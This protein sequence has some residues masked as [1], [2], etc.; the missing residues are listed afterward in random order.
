[1]PCPPRGTVPVN[2]GRAWEIFSL[3]PFQ[4]A[5]GHGC[6][7]PS[8][9]ATGYDIPA[10]RLSTPQPTVPMVLRFSFHILSTKNG[11]RSRGFYA[12]QS[13]AGQF[14]I[15]DFDC[16]SDHF[17]VPNVSVVSA[18]DINPSGPASEMILSGRDSDDF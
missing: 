16:F 2:E 8:Y 14:R 18:P 12:S 3:C 13:V 4:F 1:M 5:F 9:V 10:F 7:H 15:S 11:K 17:S 6:D